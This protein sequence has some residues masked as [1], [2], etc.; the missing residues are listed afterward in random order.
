MLPGLDVISLVNRLLERRASIPVLLVSGYMQERSLLS[1]AGGTPHAFLQKP[2]SARTL[3]AMVRENPLPFPPEPA[4]AIGI[5]LTRW[6][7][8][9]ADQRDGRRNLWLRSLDKLGLGF[10]S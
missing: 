7:L 8:E 5:N 10:D 9:R 1:R 4:R 6:S 3:L 2:Y